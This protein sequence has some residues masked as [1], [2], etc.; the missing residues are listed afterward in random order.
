MFRARWH[1]DEVP[2]LR[3]ANTHPDQVAR[4]NL[5]LAI[6]DK[7]INEDDRMGVSYVVD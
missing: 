6:I 5:I 7:D 1:N 2:T 3:I 4:L